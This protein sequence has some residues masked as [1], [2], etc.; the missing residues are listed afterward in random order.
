MSGG[1]SPLTKG[2]WIVR[3]FGSKP[4]MSTMKTA[5]NEE[6]MNVSKYEIWSEGFHVMEGQS[7][8]MFHGHAEGKNFQDAVENFAKKNPE[9]NSSYDRQRMTY[10]GCQLY[11]NESDARQ[12]F[13]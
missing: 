2:A 9:F 4:I 13:G 8:A 3:S 5:S 12:S 11:S 1:R 6:D 10:W 7:G